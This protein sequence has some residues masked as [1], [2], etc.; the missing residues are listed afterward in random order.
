MLRRMLPVFAFCLLASLSARAQD[1]KVEVFGGYSYLHFHNSPSISLNGWEASAQYK[2]TDWLGG[3]ADFDGHYG[4]LHGAGTSTYTYL[5]GPQVSWP[6]R[7]L[8]RR[9][10]RRIDANP[11]LRHRATVNMAGLVMEP[12]TVLD[13]LHQLGLPDPRSRRV[14]AA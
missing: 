3:V 11:R 4:S 12:F 1:D 5:F 13:R 8:G 7:A 6:A 10:L 9:V 2:F 14:P